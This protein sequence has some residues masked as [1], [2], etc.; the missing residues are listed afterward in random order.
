MSECASPPPFGAGAAGA[1]CHVVC[2]CMSDALL[3][4]RRQ[5]PLLTMFDEPCPALRA[6]AWLEGIQIVLTGGRIF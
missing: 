4:Y 1:P 2:C 6:V 3:A 5:A